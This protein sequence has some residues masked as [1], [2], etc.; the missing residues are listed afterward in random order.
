VV[1]EFRILGPLEA[2]RDGAAVQLGGPK[3]RAVLAILLAH[4]GE[5]VPAGR[6][7]D[8]LWDDDPPATSANVLQGYVSA[9]RKALGRDAIVTRGAGYAVVVPDGTLDLQLFERH[10]SIG[11]EA[12]DRGDAQAA[13]GS[14]RAALALWR[15]PALSDL[16]D[17]PGA[18]SIAGRLDELRLAALER[19][20]E[21]DLACGRDAEVVAELSELTAEHPLRERFRALQ[22][23]ALYRS[24]RQADALDAYRDARRTLVGELG[25]EPGPALQELESSIL[26]QDASLLEPHRPRGGPHLA[27]ARIV[28]LCSLELGSLDA[29]VAIAEPLA[30]AAAGR[31][32]VLAHTVSA[33][34]DLEG[35]SAVLHDRRAALRA[36]GVETRAAAFTSVTPGLDLARLAEEQE[37]VLIVVDAPARLLEDAR[38]LALLGAAPCDVAVHVGRDPRPG[39][40]LVPFSGA[41]HD[42]AAVELGAWL[43]ASR[44]VPLRL[45]GA[46]TERND[47]SRL[48]ASA[49]LAVQRT[50]GVRVEPVLVDPTPEA[51]LGAAAAAGVV[52]VGLTDRWQREGLGRTRTALFTGDGPP[53]LL[54]RRGERPGGLAPRE[55]AT[56]FTWTLLPIAAT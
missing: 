45:A 2:L 25:I 40:V 15:G 34:H 8:R 23:L 39:S 26:R 32:L 5:T 21:A 51:L 48:L 44:E 27:P 36:R 53:T 22:M 3:Q 1:Q 4:A 56:R 19:R 38:L 29:L 42:W 12:L 14:F 20:I 41:S 11:A 49:S 28:L 18:Q 6:L 16:A 24:G 50:V 31:Q 10:A 9:L 52:V 37:A 55:S 17:E 30:S 46:R 7:I 35:A 13:A 33:Q 43:A 47:A 54:V